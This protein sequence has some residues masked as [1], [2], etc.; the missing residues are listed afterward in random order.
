M[1]R[2]S[3]RIFYDPTAHDGAALSD[4][5]VSEAF[6]DI[7]RH[8]QEEIALGG[9]DTGATVALEPEAGNDEAWILTV[10]TILFEDLA[11]T[12]VD[13]ALRRLQL[14]GKRL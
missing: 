14:A 6:S 10:E 11:G 5:K 9:S 13:N 2:Y 3:Y 1:N 4:E 12:L 8:V 7:D